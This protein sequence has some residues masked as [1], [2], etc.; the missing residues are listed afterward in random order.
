MLPGVNSVTSFRLIVSYFVEIIWPFWV[1]VPCALKHICCLI[2]YIFLQMASRSREWLL[3]VSSLFFLHG[4][5]NC[6][7]TPVK[8]FKYNCGFFWIVFL[9]C[10]FLFIYFAAL[11]L[12]TFMFL[13]FWLIDPFIWKLFLLSMKFQIHSSFSLLVHWTLHYIVFYFFIVSVKCQL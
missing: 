3:F 13:S 4:S 10:Q 11:I 9:F 1:N 2:E 6:W 7:E 5:I 12:G 8:V